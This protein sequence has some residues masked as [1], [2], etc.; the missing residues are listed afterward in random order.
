MSSPSRA[1]AALLVASLLCAACGEPPPAAVPVE[2]RAAWLLEPPQIRVGDVAS[3]DRLVVTPPGWSVP[4]LE[5]PSAPEGFWLLDAE[6]PATE[7]L[8]ARW[9]HRTRLRIRA[10]EV[11]RFMWPASSAEIEAPGGEKRRLELDAL[12][13]EVVSVLPEAP[14][15]LTPY[16]V[17][18]LPETSA[19]SL[20]AAAAAG[21][22]AALGA[23][24]IGLI[25]VRR[26]RARAPAPRDESAGV[27][28]EAR[29]R[30]S[31]SQA[32]EALGDD[33]EFAAHAISTALRRFVRER[34]D[35]PALSR[36]SEELAA[37]P[38]PLALA[39]RWAE[40]ARLLLAL[41]AERFAAQSQPPAA[42]QRLAPL[43]DRAEAFVAES[44]PP[45]AVR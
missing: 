20:L 19:R 44:L 38:A 7:R 31:L 17:R 3:L 15:R 43:L 34:F 13:L 30:A 21:A 35:V 32:R 42:G 40:L 11:G 4:P 22:L 8:A 36:T 33:P 29:A 5:P 16:G 45:A 14:D 9:I 23:L 10:R 39:T 24:A 26:R 6:S 2:P 37:T 18:P 27:S 12:E 25:G 1:G 28:A 41:D